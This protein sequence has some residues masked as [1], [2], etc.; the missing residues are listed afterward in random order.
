M[1]NFQESKMHLHLR[2]MLVDTCFLKCKDRDDEIQKYSK[3]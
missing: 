1:Y 3:Y 2:F